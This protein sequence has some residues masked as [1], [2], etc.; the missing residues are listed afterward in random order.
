MQA[1]AVAMSAFSW[2]LLSWTCPLSPPI[3]LLA[4]ETPLS[5]FSADRPWHVSQKMLL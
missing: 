3:A 1:D 2:C 5:T 4:T